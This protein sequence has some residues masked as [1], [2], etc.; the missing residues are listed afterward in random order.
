MIGGNTAHRRSRHAAD[1]IADVTQAIPHVKLCQAASLPGLKEDQG[2]LDKVSKSPARMNAQLT[3]LLP[4]QPARFGGGSRVQGLTEGL[5]W[6]LFDWRTG[7]GSQQINILPR[8]ISLTTTTQ[9]STASRS[10]ARLAWP[11]PS[12]HPLSLQQCFSSV[13]LRSLLRARARGSGDAAWHAVAACPIHSSHA[14]EAGSDAAASF[15]SSHS[16]P[17]G[18]RVRHE[19]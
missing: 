4:L 3:R 17:S 6:A 12:N 8:S 14:E 19:V 16:T 18:T 9:S 15:L 11:S 2:R 1:L 5:F 7:I 13:Q 10:F